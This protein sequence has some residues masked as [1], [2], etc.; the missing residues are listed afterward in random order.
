[1]VVGI[2]SSGREFSVS[3]TGNAIGSTGMQNGCQTAAEPAAEKSFAWNAAKGGRFCRPAT[4]PRVAE[5]QHRVAAG[6][7][8]QPPRR[9]N[10]DYSGVC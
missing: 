3:E 8:R 1:M 2:V 9:A 5:S 10:R 4:R 6:Q 7:R